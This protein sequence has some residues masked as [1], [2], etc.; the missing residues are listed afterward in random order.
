MTDSPAA[1]TLRSLIGIYHYFIR[2]RT[3]Q[4][5]SQNQ[6]LLNTKYVILRGW[7][8]QDDWEGNAR[9]RSESKK[10]GKPGLVS[11]SPWNKTV[12]R[13]TGKAWPQGRD[14]SAATP[15][16][17]TAIRIAK[18]R[19]SLEYSSTVKKTSELLS[20]ISAAPFSESPKKQL[21]DKY[22]DLAFPK[23]Q[24]SRGNFVFQFRDDHYVV[25][26]QRYHK[27]K[28]KRTPPLVMRILPQKAPHVNKVSLVL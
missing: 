2:C 27:A 16:I 15:R 28:K 5:L 8:E 11:Q 14:Y 13:A 24:G 7:L 19:K 25:V 26:K 20:F 3:L 9:R 10:P 22:E 1:K 17:I 18:I 6:N 21:K 12:S 23:S 4:S